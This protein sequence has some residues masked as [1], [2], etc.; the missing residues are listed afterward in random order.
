MCANICTGID[1]SFKNW[2]VF[3]IIENSILNFQYTSSNSALVTSV[4]YHAAL[5]QP[6]HHALVR[7]AQPLHPP[8]EGKSPGVSGEVHGLNISIL[9]GCRQNILKAFE[10]NT[11]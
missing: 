5:A 8:L 6:H 11:T 2:K 9:N 1:V 3:Q 7:Q 4:P 10:K